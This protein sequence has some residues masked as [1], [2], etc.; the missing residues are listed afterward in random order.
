MRFPQDQ[1]SIFSSCPTP[2]G[3]VLTSAAGGWR[4]LKSGMDSIMVDPT[5][6]KANYLR[7]AVEAAVEIWAPKSETGLRD[8][9]T[10]GSSGH[11][12]VLTSN[13]F[14]LDRLLPDSRFQVHVI[15]AGS[16]PWSLPPKYGHNGWTLLNRS[17]VC[18]TDRNGFRKSGDPF[19]SILKALLE[20]ARTLQLPD[21]LNRV[22]ISINPSS[23]SAIE[24]I[25]GSTCF[26]SLG[27][28]EA[29]TVLVKVRP[30]AQAASSGLLSGFPRGLRTPSGR[31]DVERELD[32]ALED[33][34]IPAFTIQMRYEHS[35]L[36]SGTVCEFNRDVYFRARSQSQEALDFSF[37][38]GHN[39]NR[40]ACSHQIV[41]DRLA[42]HLAISQ[43]PRRGLTALT[44]QF[45]ANRPRSIPPEYVQTII[46]E[47]KYQAR[48]LERFDAPTAQSSVR[49]NPRGP[50][51][52]N[53]GPGHS[54][55]QHLNESQLTL[56][57][58]RLEESF[59]RPPAPLRTRREDS[60][61]SNDEARQLW[62]ALR[63]RKNPDGENRIQSVIRSIPSTDTLRNLRQT[64]QKNRRSI[65]QDTLRSLRYE[66]MQENVAPWL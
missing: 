6:P 48:T 27:A 44:N 3:P 55:F 2:S 58:L 1:F 18:G 42:F 10:V 50:A 62:Q 35:A 30:P 5:K 39:I 24:G 33:G 26:A 40:Y 34:H 21:R 45:V 4:K 37:T 14:S 9:S 25:L 36:P 7:K 54:I 60:D 52:M 43:S 16:L 59:P 38:T 46:D 56:S 49:R 47:L 11:I 61:D 12:F 63:I 17:T 32:A 15:C 8:G 20:S 57:G 64:A 13:T 23:N 31:V 53:P 65:G 51:T 22:R 41:Q 29:R 66:K 28:G 19:S